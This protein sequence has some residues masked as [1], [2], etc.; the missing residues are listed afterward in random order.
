V[1]LHNREIELK[2][3]GKYLRNTMWSLSL[4]LVACSETTEMPHKAADQVLINGRVYTVDEHREWA[5]AVAITN[6]V[7]DFVGSSHRVF[8]GRHF[9]AG[10]R[11]P[12]I[13]YC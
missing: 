1:V 2:F 3:L 9:M 5:E 6:G 7:I 12:R 10:D 13:G 11:R 8:T 4:L